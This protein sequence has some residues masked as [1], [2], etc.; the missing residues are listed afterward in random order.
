MHIYRIRRRNIDKEHK[1]SHR[2]PSQA[3]QIGHIIKMEEKKT[4]NNNKNKK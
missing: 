1:T 3:V 4:K 2:E